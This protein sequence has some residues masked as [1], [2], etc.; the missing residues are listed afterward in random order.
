VVTYKSVPHG[1]LLGTRAGAR[2]KVSFLGSMA[3]GSFQPV[4]CSPRTTPGWPSWCGPSRLSPGHEGR[5]LP[6]REV[7]RPDVADTC[8]HADDVLAVVPSSERM[9]GVDVLE[10][11]G[12]QDLPCE[13][14]SWAL[15][16]G[17]LAE[18]VNSDL[19]A[20]DVVVG[21]LTVP[22]PVVRCSGGWPPA[23][24]ISPN[25]GQAGESSGAAARNAG[26]GDA[27]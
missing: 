16:R 22:G 1:Y 23:G 18:S 4:D 20:V 3:E 15:P 24:S 25:R 19:S 17:P 7:E 13:T 12:Q 9:A 21:A 27:A 11:F 26:S 14:F 8:A 5:L 10:P 2:T 6:S